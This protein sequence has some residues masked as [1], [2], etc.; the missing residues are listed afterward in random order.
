MDKKDLDMLLLLGKCEENR[1][2]I[3]AAAAAGGGGKAEFYLAKQTYSKAIKLDPDGSGKA[4][5]GLERASEGMARAAGGAPAAA[6][7]PAATPAAAPAASGGAAVNLDTLTEAAALALEGDALAA[8]ATELSVYLFK[9]P[10]FQEKAEQPK[11]LQHGQSA[12]HGSAPARLL[13]LLGARLAALGS[14]ALTRRGRPT[15][16]PATASDARTSRLQVRRSH[17]L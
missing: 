11:H 3:A 14:S 16:R 15:G 2:E 10:P 6:A 12:P 5:K 8:V 1:A 9:S 4:A 13:Y 7:A 17:C